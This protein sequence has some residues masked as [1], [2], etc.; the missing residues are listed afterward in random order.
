VGKAVK[1]D[2][3]FCAVCSA[4]GRGT[5]DSVSNLKYFIQA[6]KW[7][8][9]KLLWPHN[10]PSLFCGF[11]ETLCGPPEGHVTHIENHFCMNNALARK[12]IWMVIVSVIV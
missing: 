4:A 6:V 12:E 11:L 7:F 5:L 1:Y 3:S 8:I 2:S 9:Q 10:F